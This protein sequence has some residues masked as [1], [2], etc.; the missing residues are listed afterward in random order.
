MV[1]GVASFKGLSDAPAV[2]YLG[3]QLALLLT[4]AVGLR[5][6]A[7]RAM[8]IVA[9]RDDAE[10]LAGGS[11]AIWAST[12]STARSSCQQWGT[13]S[14]RLSPKVTIASSQRSFGF[15]T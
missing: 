2:S 10:F 5:W 15:L 4:L 12:V 7:E 6:I 8:V 9:H 13:P 14:R 1:W 3:E 11:V